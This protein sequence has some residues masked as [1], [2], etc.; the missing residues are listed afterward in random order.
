MI[1]PLVRDIEWLGLLRDLPEWTP[2][3]KSTLVIVPH[4]DDETLG[5][6]GFIAVQR[7]R[8]VDITVV[9]VTDGEHAYADNAGL[10]E[11][12]RSEQ[13][14]ALAQL[15]VPP[16]KIIRLEMPDSAVETRE[17][18][19]ADKLASLASAGTLIVA[20]WRGDFHPDHQ[21]CGRAAQQ[22]AQ[23]SGAALA[24]YFFWTWHMVEPEL[25][26]GLPLKAF[27]LS[28]A[29]A[30]AKAKALQQHR[31]QLFRA[32]GDPILPE[33]LLGPSKWP[34]EIFAIP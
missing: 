18:Q 20:P 17:H 22:A 8:G 7:S 28:T 29:F 24:S 5:A 21:A 13:T 32:D 31:S 34:F 6:G 27:R 25:V 14:A 19:L 23:L 4:P 3:K 26:D 16:E 12:R 1:Q 10:R 2:P 15:G 30:D 9:A 11:T 33:E